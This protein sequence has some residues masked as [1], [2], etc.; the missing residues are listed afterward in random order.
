MDNVISYVF[1]V[2]VPHKGILNIEALDY[3]KL[4]RTMQTH[5]ASAAPLTFFN[6]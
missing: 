1:K 6:G 5:S 2:L 3:I 4:T